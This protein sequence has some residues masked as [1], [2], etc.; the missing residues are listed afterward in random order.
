MEDGG[1]ARG[2]RVAD[3]GC[4]LDRPPL[5]G[6]SSKVVW[7]HIIIVRWTPAALVQGETMIIQKLEK[8]Q[9]KDAAEIFAKAMMNDELHVFFFPDQASRFEK[10]VYLYE[11]KLELQYRKCIVTSRKLEGLAIWEKPGQ[12]HSGLSLSEMFNGLKLIWQCGIVSLIKMIK[13]Q[14]WASK[15]RDKLINQPYWYL[16]VVI[17]NPEH[18]GKGF[19]SQLI[20]PILLEAE[21]NHQEV[22]LETQNKNNILIYDK[23]GFSLIKEIKLP[24]TDIIQY[25]MK[26]K[27]I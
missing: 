6:L 16:D 4:V 20:K 8:N 21:K 18:Q 27:I 10:L 14:T 2:H 7:T 3:S 5:D 12:Q 24:N 17:V 11:F 25:C 9:I 22:Y 23:Y 15:T 26:K 13:Y 1:E 19:A